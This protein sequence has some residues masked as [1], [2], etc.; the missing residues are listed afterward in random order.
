MQ[1]DI[2]AAGLYRMG[3]TAGTAAVDPLDEVGLHGV[4]N[5]RKLRDRAAGFHALKIAVGQG[6]GNLRRQ[7]SLNGGTGKQRYAYQDGIFELPLGI[8]VAYL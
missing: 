7:P 4:R 8:A 5:F 6:V 3:Q 2:V 1:T